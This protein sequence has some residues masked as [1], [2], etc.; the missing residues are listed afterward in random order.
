MSNDFFQF[1]KFKVC[2]AK[3]AMKVG[4]DAVLLGSWAKGG[5]NILD[6]GTGSG[7]IAMMMSQRNP[8]AKV[9]GI[10][11]SPDA[12]LQAKEN[13]SNSIFCNN[14]DMQ[15]SDI[16]EFTL[17]HKS[18]FDCIV[19]NPPYFENSLE[20]PVEER[21]YARHARTLPY[22]ILLSCAKQLLTSD[23]HLY[24]ILPTQ[25]VQHIKAEAAIQELYIHQQCDIKTT[26]RKIAK[27]TLLDLSSLPTTSC[28][29]TTQILI[30]EGKRSEWFSNL[31]KEFY[32]N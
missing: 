2:H 29:K 26:E 3:C 22:S 19:S 7:I 17:N 4:T 15:L 25:S 8:F 16:S 20:C 6:V 28:V 9:T 30:K 32:L 24:L 21:T 13:V 11:I 1:K 12:I 27:R 18:A 14:I 10:D 5:T 31:T 23:G